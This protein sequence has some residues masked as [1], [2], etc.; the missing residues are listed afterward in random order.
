M[1]L[2]I[3]RPGSK[4]LTSHRL[5]EII[6]EIGIGWYHIISF[7]ILVCMPLAEGAGM[8]VMTN[9]THSLKHQ[10]HLSTWQ[11]GSL[12]AC[13]F[14]GL[15]V[16]HSVA[17]FLADLKGRRLPIVLGYLG[18]SLLS[19]FMTMSSGYSSMV[20]LRILHGIACGIG[21]PPAMS[22]IAEIMP[23]D[24]R[25][26]MFIVFWSFTAVG[27]TYAAAG[28]VIFMPELKED[29]WKQVVLWSAFPAFAMLLLSVA[30]LQESAHWLA[31]RGRLIEARIVL[32][33][34]AKLNGKLSIL[35]KLGPP[36][37]YDLSLLYNVA[38]ITARQTTRDREK[39]ESQES[40]HASPTEILRIL[41]QPHLLKMVVL[42]SI[43]A[44]VGNIQTFG[45]SNVWPELL[46]HDSH[47]LQYLGPAQ[48]LMLLVSV[49][50][51]VGGVCAL[52]S[53][54]K[55]ASHRIYILFS[56][57]LGCIGLACV[58]AFEHASL[59]LL[60]MLITHMS[61]TL[62]YSVSMIFCEESFPT[63]IRASATGVV[64]FWGTLWSVASPLLLTAV[65]ERGFIAIAGVA[66]AVAAL[67]IVPLKETRGAEL[68]DF[69]KQTSEAAEFDDEEEEESEDEDDEDVRPSAAD[70]QLSWLFANGTIGAAM[71]LSM[72]SGLLGAVPGVSFTS[73][74]SSMGFII[75]RCKDRSFF[76]KEMLLGNG[77]AVVML[78]LM[79]K[80]GPWMQRRFQLQR[81]IFLRLVLSTHCLALVNLLMSLAEDE[82]SMLVMGAVQSFLNAMVLN[83]SHSLAAAM[84]GN[85]RAWV[86][87][88]FLSGA[89]LPV[90]TTPFTGFGPKSPLLSRVAFY[91][92][93]ATFCFLIGLLLGVYHAKVKPHL[94]R[95]PET[96]ETSET[97]ELGGPRGNMAQLAEAYRR[98]EQPTESA[99][100]TESS[101]EASPSQRASC[102]FYVAFSAVLCYQMASYFFAGL[103]PLLGD[104]AIALHMYLYMI[105]G[106]M[107]GS[108][109]AFIWTSCMGS[110]GDVSDVSIRDDQNQIYQKYQKY[111]NI[112]FMALLLL[113]FLSTTTALIPSISILERPGGISGISAGSLVFTAF[114]FGSFSKAGLEALCPR[115]V[116]ARLAGVLLGLSAVLLCYETLLSRSNA[117]P[118][119]KAHLDAPLAGSHLQHQQWRS[120]RSARQVALQI[121][122]R[123]TMRREG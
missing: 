21:V 123:G 96:S 83:T 26:F 93:P 29:S 31:V 106:D 18:I 110:I 62:E 9:I 66:F 107:V 43:L 102:R 67:A 92:V 33:H 23:S 59:L 45:L 49:G 115:V 1:T 104:A 76:T 12:D 39:E 99:E 5:P 95:E 118:E 3:R 50:I 51:P 7:V 42:F 6:N 112:T 86:Q 37:A 41:V 53:N 88:G 119:I 100:P 73:F 13:S 78:L 87:L 61:G 114:F 77:V 58:A 2:E 97:L 11:A 103:F 27:E 24:W 65:G 116:K 25:P 54:S 63:A 32:E 105:C 69:A 14:T 35:Q 4:M 20:A 113:S 101:V 75:D 72:L 79:P 74:Y 117:P 111:Q 81:S 68:Q 82:I 38:G 30:R 80:I 56:G 57:L 10:F 91:A 40:A 89:L 22:M 8:I 19:L 46:R 71:E 34:M 70:V 28:M 60:A 44:S 55:K 121:S 108:L 84:T 120:Q 52:I 16:G 17:G 48:K 85:R 94:E 47:G 98:F 122:A 36:P 15:A 109:I 64:I 90:V